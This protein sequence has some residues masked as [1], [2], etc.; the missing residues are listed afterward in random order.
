MGSALGS[1]FKPARLTPRCRKGSALGRAWSGPP[2]LFVC[3]GLMV[4]PPACAQTSTI[5]VTAP[6]SNDST[7]AS[8]PASVVPSA[9]ATPGS[10]S[11]NNAPTSWAGTITTGLQ[12]EGGIIANP[13]RPADGENFGDIYTDHANQAQ[14]N[15]LLATITRPTNPNAAGYDVG[16]DL[17]L[18]YGSD[19]RANHY[20]GQFDRLITQR[21]QFG[22]IQAD[23]L[24][25]LPWVTSAG[26]DVKIGEFPSIMGLEVLDPSGNPFYSHSFIYNWGVTFFDTGL[27]ATTHLNPTVD[28]YYGVSTG[29]TTTFGAGDN[30]GAPAGYVGFG[31]NNLFKGRVTVLATAH[32][33]PEQSRR[34]DPNADSDERYYADVLTTWK[35]NTKLTSN[36]ELNFIKDD[37]DRGDAYGFAQYLAYPL[38]PT[39][40]FNL[41]GEVWRDGTGDFVAN[42]PDDLGFVKA[43]A[44]YPTS[45][46]VAPPTTYSELTVGVT[47]KPP[48]PKPVALFAIR[49][50]VRYER[51]LNGTTPFVSGRDTGSFLFGGDV[52]LGF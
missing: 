50:E 29:N 11:A 1:A 45:A 14:L 9:T 31:L 20:L 10:T 37:Y 33:G 22:I 8:T 24:L 12:F 16:F 35:I 40:T 41:R 52:I 7:P 27:I 6:A 13:A 34:V 5:S 19:M 51:S 17:Q 25:H 43:E 26:T 4:A 28:L 23:L 32:I 48:M 18:L 47:Y 3:V 21:Y 44:G 46:I 2:I 49:P 30:N 38:S 42:F 15:E 39:V 36:T